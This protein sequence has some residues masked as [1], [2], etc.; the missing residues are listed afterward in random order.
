MGA[1]LDRDW[2]G[3]CTAAADRA[4][5]HLGAL[6]PAR[7]GDHEGWGADGTATA[8]ADLAAEDALLESL[9]AAV[10]DATLV[11]EEAGVVEGSGQVMLIV[12][13]VDGTNNAIRS[14]P[15]WAVSIAVVVDG[16]AMGGFVRNAG[17]GEDLYAWRGTGVWRGERRVRSANVTRLIDASLAMQRPAEPQAFLRSRGFLLGSKVPRIFGAAAL[18]MALV[19]CGALDAYVNVN[20]NPDYPFGERVVDYAAAAVIV[21][22]GGGVATDSAGS[23]LPIE[24]DLSLR[25]PVAVAATPELHA[26][27]L[28]VLSAVEG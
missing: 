5:E 15:Y 3:I 18:D 14:I 19:G 27:V 16:V 9:A 8:A 23:P 10:P 13:P 6:D 24:A 4:M 12:D 1:E 28:A 17:N 7:W 21:E 26:E 11:S 25:V 2:R 22:T 20:T